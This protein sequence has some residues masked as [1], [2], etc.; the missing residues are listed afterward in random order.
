MRRVKK[1]YKHKTG[2]NQ[3]EHVEYLNFEFVL[4][5]HLKFRIQMAMIFFFYLTFKNCRTCGGKS[6]VNG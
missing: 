5:F 6:I 1:D 3:Y 2:I 4:F